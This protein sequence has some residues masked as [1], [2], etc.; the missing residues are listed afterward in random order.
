MLWNHFFDEDKESV[1]EGKKEEEDEKKNEDDDEHLVEQ[2]WNFRK[3][4]SDKIQTFTE[5]MKFKRK[6]RREIKEKIGG[7]S[8][9]LPQT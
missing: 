1:E 4:I 3:D 8:P 5:K 9:Y 2:I 6:L 7:V